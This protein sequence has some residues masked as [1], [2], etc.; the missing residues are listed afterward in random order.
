MSSGISRDEWLKA[1][2]DA[3]LVVVD[4]QSAVSVS[5]FGT[6]FGIERTAA[7]RRLSQLEALGRAV[8]TKK[9]IRDAT[10]RQ[11]TVTAWKLAETKKKRR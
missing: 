8:R 10:N 1:L 4:D 5:E 7:L 11:Y 9:R 2:D 3:G 6:M